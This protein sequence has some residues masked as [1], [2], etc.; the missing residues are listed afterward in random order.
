[1]AHSLS[2]LYIQQ[3]QILISKTTL[4]FHQQHY[5]QQLNHQS[6]QNVQKFILSNKMHRPMTKKHPFNKTKLYQQNNFA[7]Q[8]HD[9]L[10]ID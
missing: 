2:D 4:H 8:V 10:T 5:S 6:F 7:N 1:M 9:F 3:L